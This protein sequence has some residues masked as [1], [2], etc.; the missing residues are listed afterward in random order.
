MDI[1]AFF[2]RRRA[3]EERVKAARAP[4]ASVRRDHLTL[5]AIFDE[6]AES[7]EQSRPADARKTLSPGQG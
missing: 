6:R 2:N 3:Q 4:N 1:Y 7:S 5:A